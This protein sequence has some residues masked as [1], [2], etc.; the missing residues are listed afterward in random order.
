MIC[1][2]LLELTVTGGGVSGTRA[3]QCDCGGRSQQQAGG[4]E[5]ADLVFHVNDLA[6][7]IH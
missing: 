4:G 7:I 1:A 5:V 2:T 3:F 6:Q